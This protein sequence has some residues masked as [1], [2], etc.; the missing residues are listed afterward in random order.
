MP[1]KRLLLIV[2]V[3]LALLA[4]I[5]LS[6]VIVASATR[7]WL[8]WQAHRQHLK[9]ELGKLSAP[10]VQPV[11]LERVRITNEAGVSTQIEVTAEHA[12]LRLSLARIVAGK[13]YGIH[14]LSI[15]N[16]R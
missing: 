11:A 1:R 8:H 5:A 16:A 9:I 10:L 3:V 15:Q 7:G 12:I 14:G 13:A 6:P 4:G 2:F